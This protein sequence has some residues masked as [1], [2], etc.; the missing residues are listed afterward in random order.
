MLSVPLTYMVFSFGFACVWCS[1]ILLFNVKVKK[2]PI[3]INKGWHLPCV[4][5]VIGGA[6]GGYNLLNI[7]ALQYFE[8]YIAMPVVNGAIIVL[9]MIV[10]SIIDK[11]KPTIKSLIGFVSALIAIVLLNL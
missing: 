5:L 6:V 8:S 4:A 7:Y 2:Q 9:V 10:N 1:L 3:T 11:A